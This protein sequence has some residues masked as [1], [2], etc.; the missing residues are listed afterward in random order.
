MG[1]VRFPEKRT[2]GTDYSQIHKRIEGG[3]RRGPRGQRIV[4]FVGV[5]GGV[6]VHFRR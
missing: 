2:V 3:P 5:V 6:A 1:A 4:L